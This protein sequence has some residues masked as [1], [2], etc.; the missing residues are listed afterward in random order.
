MRVSTSQIFDT[1]TLA[2]QRDQASLFKLQNQLSTGRRMLTPADDPVA[3][4]QA[5][6][7]A[8][9]REVNALHLTNQAAA[10]G[11]LNLVDNKLDGV[12]DELQGILER[13]V[14]GGNGSLSSE[15]KGMIAEELKRRLENIIG[16]ANSQDGTGLYVFSG[17][18]S[19]TKPFE[20][21]SP[22][23]PPPFSLAN[24]YANYNGDNG[25]RKLQVSPSQE[26]SMSEN[27]AEV[28]MQVRDGQGNLTG[29]SMFDSIKNLVDILD[30]ASG[31]PF[32]QADYDQAVG[33]MHAALDNVSRVRASVGARLA[34]LD[35]LE[36][37]GQDLNL[38]YEARLSE[39]QDLD[40]AKAIS[41]LTRQQM[42]LEAA[43][44][45]FKQT[46]QLSLFNY[47]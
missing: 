17:F 31:V 46:S 27:G 18:Q 38:Q 42:Q 32:T 9:S 7:V 13:A 19:Q 11:Q 29:R 2:I 21:V 44:K 33:D 10:R 34:A 8:Q 3:S 23:A 15:Q 36:E 43:Q 30:P 24:R 4:A 5:L 12:T 20:V 22:A 14:Q 41:D 25:Q 28:F 45:S 26:L 6:V 35:D 47:I 37:S 16:L 1:G 39:L 40:Y